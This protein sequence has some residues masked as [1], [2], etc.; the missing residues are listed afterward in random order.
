MKRHPLLILSLLLV[1]LLGSFAN[2]QTRSTPCSPTT[3]NTTACIT[4][5][6]TL[7]RTD[8]TPVLLPI[9]YLVEQ[10]T[11]TSGTWSTAGT[12]TQL[13]LA[14]PNL[15]PGTYFFRGYTIEGSSQSGATP[16]AS[17]AVATP[18]PAPPNAPPNFTIAVIIS[19][20]HA[21]IYSV[22][23]AAPN[24]QPGSY[25]GDVRVGRA[26]GEYVFT[27]RSKRFHRVEVARKETWGYPASGDLRNLAA[28]C[29]PRA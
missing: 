8:G 28:P 22:V 16:A 3:P 26:C 6:Q 24:Y 27:Y 20:D 2:A 23:G 12:T 14:V 5:S 7:T 15:A 21:P 13:Q 29:A 9:S 18:P 10:R 19:R 1:S 4:W 25:Y 17:F 11:G